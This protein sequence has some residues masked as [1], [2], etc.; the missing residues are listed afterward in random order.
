MGEIHIS[1][2]AIGSA[3]ITMARRI[4]KTRYGFDRIVAI[5]TSERALRLASNADQKIL[6]ASEAG[7]KP[8]SAELAR[9]CALEQA[10]VLVSALGDSSLVVI[11]AGLGGAAGTGISGVVATLAKG[12]GALTL[13]FASM[14]FAFED[15]AHQAQASEGLQ[16]LQRTADHVLAISNEDQGQ[17]FGE[18]LGMDALL[19]RQL[20]ALGNYLW[21][22][23]A[24]RGTGFV[25]IDLED[26][27]SALAMHG[28]PHVA[29]IFWGEA[30][31]PDRSEFAIRRALVGQQDRPDGK[32]RLFSVSVSI[33]AMRDGPYS[34]KMRE[35]NTVMN[36]VKRLPGCDDVSS[37]IFSGD[38]DE[39]LGEKL[40]VSV[41]AN[42]LEREC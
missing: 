36:V 35:I 20:A 21:H 31:G 3:G 40:Q 26:V 37:L 27:L 19:Q 2:I 4:D 22:A 28:Q 16:R 8:A 24:A 17:R 34:L 30:A 39:A 23:S 41:V 32:F 18:H 13:V 7:K 15:L 42:Y 25:G 12:I 10:D 33:R 6:L 38:Y 5:D 11:V 29:R 1:L 9:R 14:P